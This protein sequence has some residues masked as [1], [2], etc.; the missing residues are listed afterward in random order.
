MK[1]RALSFALLLLTPALS[2]QTASFS[3]YGSGC[4]AGGPPP[5]L[6]SRDVPRLGSNFTV[7]YTGP[8]G[9]TPVSMDIPLLVTGFQQSL[10]TIPQFS[11]IQPANC[12]LLTVPV[13]LELMPLL[14]SAYQSQVT[15]AIPNDRNLLGLTLFQQW[16]DLYFRC[17]GPCQLL[18]LRTSNGGKAVIGT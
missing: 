5:L 6:N 12:A 14:G 18:M 9:N 10:L 15:L 16:V 2:A 3:R 4:A 8:N 17:S 13:L 7:S 1:I 11:A